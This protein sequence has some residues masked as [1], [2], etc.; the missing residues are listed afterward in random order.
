MIERVILTGFMGAGKS[1]VGHL[2]ARQSGWDFLDLDTHIETTNGASARE[3]FA[4]LGELGFRQLESETFTSALTRSKI[5]VAPGGAVIDRIENQHALASCTNKLVIFLDGPFPTLIERCKK[6]ER[7]GETTYRPLLHQ[8]ATASA[9]YEA[10]RLLYASHAQAT[11]DV[12]EKSPE[13]VARIIF[14]RM[15]GHSFPISQRGIEKL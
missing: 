12:A 4:S 10:R 11:V 9:R 2:L 3:L 15:R 14:E 5:I 13:E 7:M 6:Q 8:P 1:T